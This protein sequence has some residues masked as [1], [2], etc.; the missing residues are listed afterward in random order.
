MQDVLETVMIGLQELE[1]DAGEAQ[2]KNVWRI[3]ENGL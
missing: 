1:K 2:K 3:Q